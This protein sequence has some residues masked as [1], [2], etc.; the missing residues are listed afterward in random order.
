[1]GLIPETLSTPGRDPKTA[2]ILL[3]GRPKVGKTTLAASEPG[4]LLIATEVGYET[5]PGILPVY[6]DSWR[7][8]LAVISEAAQR[9]DVTRFCI[10]TFTKL[11]KLAEIQA[12]K[13]LDVSSLADAAYGKGYSRMN[14]LI[15]E[16]MTRLFSFGRQVVFIAHTKETIIKRRGEEIPVITVDL[17][18]S[19]QRFIQAEVDAL[20]FYTLEM[21]PRTQEQKR[22][23]YFQGREDL[24]IGGRY[25]PGSI[26]PDFIEI[27]KPERQAGWPLVE[28]VLKAG[29]Q[30]QSSSTAAPE[31]QTGARR[32]RRTASPVPA[33]KQE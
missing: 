19:A 12:C 7:K 32:I 17:P 16:G 20:L 8:Y 15:Q 9:P 21:D 29:F 6:V 23:L 26:I 4:T 14:D 28:L 27:P 5:I 30:P 1:M 24:E 13:D 33:E 31:K 11:S 25:L 2:K 10:D 18:K 3:M 22:I